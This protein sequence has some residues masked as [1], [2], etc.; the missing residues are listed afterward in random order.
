MDRLLDMT[1]EDGGG[2]PAKAADIRSGGVTGR[3]S[4]GIPRRHRGTRCQVQDQQ[5]RCVHSEDPPSVRG[6][7]QVY[8]GVSENVVSRLTGHEESWRRANVFVCSQRGMSRSHFAYLESK[9]ISLG[10]ASPHVEV[11]NEN[12]PNPPALSLPDERVVELYL[13]SLVK[14]LN[15]LLGLNFGDHA[16]DTLFNSGTYSGL[17]HGLARIH[18]WTPIDGVRTAEGG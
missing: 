14:C 8:V 4:C 18:R 2:Q 6:L 9:L 3:R 5:A 13:E 10:R 17:S 11:R 7:P 12:F 16:A 15:F 1:H